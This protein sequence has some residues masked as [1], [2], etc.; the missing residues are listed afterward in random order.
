MS[1][2]FG[3][4]DT[5]TLAGVTAILEE[6]P[7]VGGHSL[8]T[9]PRLGMPGRYFYGSSQT[10]SSFVFDVLIQGS[11]KEQAAER[12]DNFVGLIA[13]YRGAHD[14]IL[15]LDTAWCWLNTMIS[16]E[17]N[18]SRVT[19]E[20][21]L[22][23]ILRASVTFETTND[24]LAVEVEPQSV[25]FATSTVYTLDVGNTTAY[26]QIEFPSGA[27]ATVN[28]GGFSVDIAATPAGLIN[29]LDYHNLLFYQKP[30]GG[31]RGASIVRY[32][33]HYRR[34]VLTPGNSVTVSAV[35]APAGTRVFYPNAR[36]I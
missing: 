12:R 35:G 33:S 24:A 4:V 25:S 29:V 14:L 17:I 34:P 3:G 13:P 10:H 21:G 22:G 31:G 18:W 27:A 36:R 8:E 26:P 28:I 7:S 30:A 15:D 6:W 20:P 32:M 1:F 16:D 23:F 9:E 11:T 5:K 19:W 2:K